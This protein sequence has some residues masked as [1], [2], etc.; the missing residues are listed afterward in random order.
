MPAKVTVRALLGKRLGKEAGDAMA[1]KIDKM[2]SEK[3]SAAQ[4]EKAFKADL[5]TH[6]QKQATAAFEEFKLC[7]WLQPRENTGRPVVRGPRIKGG[8][9]PLPKGRK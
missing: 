5:A 4:V 6:F 9:G 7:L 3:K 2:I 8:P 1:A